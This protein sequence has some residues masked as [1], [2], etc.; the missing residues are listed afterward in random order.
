[1]GDEE[2][3]ASMIKA[4]KLVVENLKQKK[5]LSGRLIRYFMQMGIFL[6]EK[7]IVEY[8]LE[9]SNVNFLIRTKYR[10][11]YKFY[12]II[13]IGHRTKKRLKNKLS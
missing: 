2:R 11:L 3:R 9:I 1:M 8:V 6:K 4:V 13:V 5:L 7:S 10:M 12:P